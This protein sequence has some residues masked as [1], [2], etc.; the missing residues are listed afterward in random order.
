MVLRDDEVFLVESLSVDYKEQK[1]GLFGLSS[2][3]KYI[4]ALDGINLRINEGQIIALIG[5][6]GAGKST[7]L[8]ALTGLVRPSQGKITSRG[9]VILLAGTDPGFD[10]DASG[11]SNIRDLAVAYG[12][13]DIEVDSFCQEIIDFSGLSS[14]IDRNVRGYSSGMRGKLGFGFIT[15]LKPDILLIDETLGVGDAEFREKAQSRLV[16]FVN[17]S[18]TVIIS[19]H[20][21]GLAKKLCNSGILLESGKLSFFGEIEDSMKAYRKILNIE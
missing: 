17:I 10:L 9:R 8:R 15:G 19:T 18:K 2:K 4:R 12:L 20:S 5:K 1:G 11:R 7:L 16:D 21:F 3:S 13:D 14:V 6:N